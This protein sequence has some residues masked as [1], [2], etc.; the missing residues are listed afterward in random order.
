MKVQIVKI[1]KIIP[2]INNPRKNQNVDK[3]ANSIKE[4]GFRQPLVVDKDYNI[5]VGHTRFQA[6]KQIGLKEVPIHIANLNKDQLKAYRIADNRVNQ[7]SEWDYKLLHNE[8]KDLIGEDYNMFTLGFEGLELENI[9]NADS[10]STKWLDQMKEWKNMPEFNH[11]DKTPYKRLVIN[12]ETKKDVDKFFKLIKQK[13]TDKTRYV[14]IP[15]RKQQVLRD[16]GY[17]SK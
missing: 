3:V 9:I 5:I 13:Y 15:K 16:K 2:Y 11:D 7:E 17:V 12:F 4:F 8:L 14:N 10:F 6:A 1:D